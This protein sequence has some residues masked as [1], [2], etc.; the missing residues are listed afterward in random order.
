[1]LHLDK[2]VVIIICFGNRPI[3]EHTITDEI[4]KILGEKVC[5]LWWRETFSPQE[6]F[7]RRNAPF[8]RSQSL[9]EGS[10]KGFADRCTPPKHIEEPTLVLK[11]RLRYGRI[12]YHEA[13]KRSGEW[14]PPKGIEDNLYDKWQSA[15]N[16]ELLIHEHRETGKTQHHVVVKDNQN[17]SIVQFLYGIAAKGISHL[18]FRQDRAHSPPLD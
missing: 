2:K 5:I 13:E 14:T 15:P 6:Q 10:P 8:R 11:T 17:N 16:V 18:T 4:T 3:H 7:S 1:M 12:S 9:P